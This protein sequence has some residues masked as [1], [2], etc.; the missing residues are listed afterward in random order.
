MKYYLIGPSP[1]PW[2]G[3]S[4][5]VYRHARALR[6]RGCDVEI[7]DFTKLH[8]GERL[9]H[10]WR[11]IWRGGNAVFHV[12]YFYPWVLLALLLR[13]FPG[14]IVYTD[15]GNRGYA[16]L[17]RLQ[18]AIFARFLRRCD[19][20]VL[21]GEH[22]KAAYLERGYTL[23]PSLTVQHAYIPPP[24]EDEPGIWASYSAETLA[25]VETR[26]PLVI[27]N[28]TGIRFH[29]GQDLYG[30]DMCIA[31][32]AALL[33]DHPGAG[34]LFA[35]PEIDDD[36]YFAEL[37]RR[38]AG[39][40]IAGA[41]HFLTGQKQLWPLFRR[42]QV[43]VRPTCVDGYGVSV[44]EALQ[45][46]CPAVASDVCARPAGTVLFRNREQAD[47]EAKV[48]AVLAEEHGDAPDRR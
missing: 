24:P 20:L 29:E 37:Q 39:L 23:P 9:R 36:G 40:G 30:I 43:M 15:H 46:G 7:L 16:G 32:V 13:P 10:L 12:N 41:V 1:P 26:R 6:A 27:A 19:E 14:R 5:Y 35:L 4:V 11:C 33:A 17:S 38:V 28:G 48:R 42:A 21:V 3:R 22:L 45:F 25:F 2:G 31:L 47:L 8:R 44:A 18:S 34:L